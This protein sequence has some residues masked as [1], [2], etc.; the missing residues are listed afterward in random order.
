M[1]RGYADRMFTSAVKAIQEKEGSRSA[2]EPQEQYFFPEQDALGRSEEEFISSRNSFYMASVTETGWPYVQHRGG[3]TGFLKVLDEHRI[4]FANF[5]GNRQYVSVGN[6]SN[7]DRVALFLMDYPRQLR[8]KIV[9]HVR[10]FDATTEPDLLTQLQETYSAR[11]DGGI[12]ITVDG[13]DWN[14]SQHI[15]QRFSQD[16]LVHALAPIKARLDELERENAEL[17]AKL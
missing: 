1:P 17:R 7:N 4:G 5:R 8:L 9:G 12:V 15:T 2:Y 10:L 11:V 16:E 3:P 14:C 6:F 13:F